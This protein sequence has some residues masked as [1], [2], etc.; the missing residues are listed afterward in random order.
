MV[1]VEAALAASAPAG[2]E[3]G[4]SRRPRPEAYG[5]IEAALPAPSEAE[6]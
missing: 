2:E 5:R 4:V 1:P 3:E 6:A